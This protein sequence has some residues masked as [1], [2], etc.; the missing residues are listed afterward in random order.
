MIR[1]R[2]G[3]FP[4]DPGYRKVSIYRLLENDWSRRLTL[5]H[6]VAFSGQADLSVY[7]GV[8]QADC[9]QA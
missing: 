4:V 9:N 1:T 2:S 7:I 5:D 8:T 3:S 6:T